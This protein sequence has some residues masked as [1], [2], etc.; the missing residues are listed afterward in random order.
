MPKEKSPG[1]DGVMVEILRLGWEFMKEDYFAVVQS[2]WDKKKLRGKDSK[3]VIKLIPKNERKHSHPSVYSAPQKWRPITLLTMIYKIIAK[4]MAVIAQEVIFVKLDFMI[5]YDMVVHGFLW[6][7]LDVMGMGEESVDRIKGLIE[8]TSEVHI[9]GICITAEEKQFES[10][11]EVIREF[12]S[13]S[14]ACLNL[15][16]SILMQLTRTATSMDETAITREIVQKLVKKL[17]H[18]SNRLLSWPAKTILLKHVLAAKP[19]YQLMLVDMCKDGLEELE[20]LWRNF[21][22]GWN[23]ERNPRHA[24][25]AWQRIAQEKKN[26]GLGWTSFKVMADALHVRLVGKILEGRDTE[27]IH[28]A[29]SFILRTLRR[30]AYQREC[31]QWTI[32]ECL[33]LL[34]LTKIEGS[35][36]LTRILGSWHRARERLRW[37]NEIGEVDRRMTML[38][39]KA[40][41]QI[42]RGRGVSSLMGGRLKNGEEH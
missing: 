10:L 37:V 41:R 11:K 17:K 42:S 26:G 4:I 33:L 23:E 31:R 40:L 25:I 13:A 18:W 22:W 3:G 38:Q 39:I 8:G 5:A 6:D 12:E 14:G 24:L 1:I 15:Q 2:F 29:Y 30:G 36:T 16:K 32:P 20:R 34:P 27:W 35:P 19:L 7:T 9:N 21:L 28:L